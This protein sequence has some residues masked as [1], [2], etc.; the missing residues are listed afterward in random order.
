[1]SRRTGTYPMHVQVVK[2]I[3]MYTLAHGHF[4]ENHKAVN[5]EVKPTLAEKLL[6]FQRNA[7]ALRCELEALFLSASI[8]RKEKKK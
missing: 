7:R 2:E 1:M 3:P 6:R 5:V 4:P 8:Q